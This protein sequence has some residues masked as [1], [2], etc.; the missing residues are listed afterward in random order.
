MG[1]GL[2]VSK[3]E[4]IWR[5]TDGWN[6]SPS[7][8]ESTANLIP[9]SGRTSLDQHDS[10]IEQALL[11]AHGALERRILELGFGD[12]ELLA[13]S[14]FAFLAMFEICRDDRICRQARS[15]RLR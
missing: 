15:T 2:A 14:L 1:D 10:R 7:S 9:R 13:A 12:F 6:P 11:L 5:G 3:T 8:E 4:R